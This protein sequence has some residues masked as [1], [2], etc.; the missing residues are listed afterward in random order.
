MTYGKLGSQ[1]TVATTL[2]HLLRSQQV[3]VGSCGTTGINRSDAMLRTTRTFGLT[4]ASPG[5]DYA[6]A[7]RACAGALS[8]PFSTPNPIR[9]VACDS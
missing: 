2:P 4:K 1:D 3:C 7:A 8:S 5:D 6:V 9:F